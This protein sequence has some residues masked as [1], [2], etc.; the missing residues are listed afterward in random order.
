LI[1]RKKEK[2]TKKIFYNFISRADAN[3]QLQFTLEVYEVPNNEEFV[4]VIKMKDF[5]F[6][7]LQ[8]I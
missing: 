1:Y 4:K 3:L 6:F 7:F 2:K 8:E 5:L